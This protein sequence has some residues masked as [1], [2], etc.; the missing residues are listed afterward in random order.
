MDEDG[1][2]G[3]AFTVPSLYCSTTGSESEIRADKRKW[4]SFTMQPTKTL[5]HQGHEASR[6]LLVSD[7][8][9]VYIR[10]LGG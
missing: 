8:P 5:N 1:V 7:I 3:N 10:V 6:R 4:L 2:L 9:F